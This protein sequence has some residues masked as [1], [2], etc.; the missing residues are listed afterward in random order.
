M[1]TSNYETVEKTPLEKV[2]PSKIVSLKLSTSEIFLSL[3]MSMLMIYLIS[4]IL[5]KSWNYTIPSLFPT[6]NIQNLTTDKAFLLLL[7]CSILFKL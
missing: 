3:I 1:N 6:L 4:I 5:K 2:E 7:I